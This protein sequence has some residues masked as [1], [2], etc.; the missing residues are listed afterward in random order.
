MLKTQCS[1]QSNLL[2]G[3][4]RKFYTSANGGFDLFCDVF[5]ATFLSRKYVGVAVIPAT[6]RPPNVDTIKAMRAW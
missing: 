6:I 2:S 3:R 1:R 5:G 4:D